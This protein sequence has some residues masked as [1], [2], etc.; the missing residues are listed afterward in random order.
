MNSFKNRIKTIL[1]TVALITA[2][3][4]PK[5]F[6]AAMGVALS[7]K[8]RSFLASQ[9]LLNAI[10]RDNKER[11][12]SILENH[13]L[14]PDQL[15]RYDFDEDDKMTPLVYAIIHN[16]TE[17]AQMLIDRG[18]N[19]NFDCDGLPLQYAVRGKHSALVSMLLDTGKLDLSLEG[20]NP[21]LLLQEAFE[22]DDALTAKLLIERFGI[23]V[24]TLCLGAKSESALIFAINHAPPFRRG[25]ASI[26][27]MLL[28]MG[29]D[30]NKRDAANKRPLDYAALQDRTMLA[31][32]MPYAEPLTED[33]ISC[34][35]Q[36]K[37]VAYRGVQQ[38]TTENIIAN[39]MCICLGN[40]SCAAIV[41]RNKA[42]LARK[43]QYYESLGEDKGA[44]TMCRDIQ[45]ILRDP[46][47]AATTPEILPFVPV[48]GVV[49]IINDCLFGE[50]MQL[51]STEEIRAAT[52]SEILSFMPV[53][54]TV[55][56]I[57]DYLLDGPV[58]S[59]EEMLEA[60][61]KTASADCE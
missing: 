60:G 27:A 37:Q 10:K 57:N 40:N 5:T 2:C 23:D 33:E 52:T 12:E 42:M 36:D 19:L 20:H 16:A 55:E 28:G 17:V 21:T 11:V 13:K 6:C 18:A 14:G 50:P 49:A 58:Q 1:I 26:V 24:H 15:L 38:V 31:L 4:A 25:P 41:E 59:I 53:P 45:Q 48:P 35:E 30:A 39:E 32:I 56:I 7:D 43:K 51:M 61:K 22:N 47:V 54:R 9:N 29:V 44:L 3:G 8:Q 34:L 46:A